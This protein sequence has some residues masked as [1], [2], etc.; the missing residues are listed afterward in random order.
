M[1]KIKTIICFT[2][3]SILLLGC[4]SIKQDNVQTKTLQVYSGAGLRKPMDELG[5]IFKEKYNI[6]VQYT[7]GGS[8]QIL[9]Q[10]ELSRKGDVFIP[11]SSF[12]YEEADKK[13]LVGE[14]YN[15]AYHI[16]V[17]V[18]PKNN[19]AEIKSIKDLGKEDV[20]VVLGDEKAC[21]IGKVSRKILE[22]EHLYEK[23][24]KNKVAST[25]TVNE[26]LVYISMKQ[27]DATIM[28]E[29]NLNDAEDVKIIEI[30]KEK[31]IIKTIPISTIRNSLNKD[32]AQEFVDFVVSHKGKN[33][34][35]KYGFQIID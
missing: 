29:D 13:G 23:V 16:P 25:A 12:Y 24:S 3:I 32:L 34:F 22:K 9:S 7:Y 20:K 5:K 2:M 30:P 28:W 6:E 33:I 8:A 21:A 11:G 10:I 14:R 4:S 19:P 15:V 17:L 26:L 27:A 1:D 31:N 18:V 35:E